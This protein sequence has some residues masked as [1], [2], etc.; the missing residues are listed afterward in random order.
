MGAKISFKPQAA[1]EKH[2]DLTPLLK[3]IEDL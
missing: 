3:L 1:R 2:G